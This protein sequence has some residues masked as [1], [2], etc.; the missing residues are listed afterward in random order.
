MLLGKERTW[1]GDLSVGSAGHAD[2]LPANGAIILA[3]TLVGVAEVDVAALLVKLS[4]TTQ[5][6][7]RGPAHL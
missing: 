6:G 5:S 4:A 7:G 3:H 1:A 2:A